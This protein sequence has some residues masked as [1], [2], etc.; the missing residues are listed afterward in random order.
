VLFWGRRVYWGGVILVLAALREGRVKGCT[1]AR[2]AQLYGVTRPTLS[3]WLRYFHEI[4]PTTNAWRLLR[5]RLWPPL[6]PGAIGEL[7]GRFVQIRGDPQGGLVAFL[8]ALR[9]GIF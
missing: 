8:L 1:A 4:F 7:L 2:I 3:R 5:A 9:V 6:R